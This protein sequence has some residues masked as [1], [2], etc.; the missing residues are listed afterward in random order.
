MQG[1]YEPLFQDKMGSTETS[2]GPAYRY[3]CSVCKL[4]FVRRNTKHSC[5]V[6]EEEIIFM[7]RESGVRGAGAREMMA[8]CVREVQDTKWEWVLEVP[9]EDAP[10]II[11]QPAKVPKP[12]K[13][14]REP[15]P[16]QFEEDPMITLEEP[17]IKRKKTESLCLEEPLTAE[18]LGHASPERENNIMKSPETSVKTK[19]ETY[20]NPTERINDK[21]ESDNQTETNVI[22]MENVNANRECDKQTDVNEMDNIESNKWAETNC[23]ASN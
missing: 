18:H 3:Q 12:Q 5:N 16:F 23:K 1:M 19:K 4:L 2:S 21:K 10:K 9:K 7:H 15:S 17:L 13:G 20:V 11:S 6:S 8:K 14:K 22:Q